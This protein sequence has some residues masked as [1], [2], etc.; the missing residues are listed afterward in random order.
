METNYTKKIYIGKNDNGKGENIYLSPP[1]WDCGGYWSFGYLGNRNC[2]YH[3]DGLSAK[4][5]TYMYDAMKKEFGDSLI[6]PENL[7][8][9]F[10]ELAKSAYQLKSTAELY[11][12]GGSRICLNRAKDTIINTDI[13]EDINNRILPTVFNAIADVISEIPEEL[14]RIRLEHI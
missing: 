6:F 10:C 14:K 9:E 13:A 1:T 12:R 7:L 8:W 2:H 5:N 11:G 3:L 4:H